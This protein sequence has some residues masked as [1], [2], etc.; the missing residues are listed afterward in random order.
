MYIHAVHSLIAVENCPDTR[1]HSVPT[2]YTHRDTA[3][4][5]TISI[6]DH[7]LLFTIYSQWIWMS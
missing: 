4:E 6:T 1:G 2:V 5:R 3:T 7:K